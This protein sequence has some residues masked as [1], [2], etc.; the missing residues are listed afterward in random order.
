MT[1]GTILKCGAPVC[2]HQYSGIRGTAVSDLTCSPKFPGSPD[3]SIALT[4][5][6]FSMSMKGD[7]LGV[8]MEG[9][10]MAPQTGAY[11]F[12]TQSDDASELRE[13][14]EKATWFF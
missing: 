3:K 11:K 13:V 6:S 1:N 10:V 7:H 12:S 5:G 2:E 4:C 14:F 8:M 9:F